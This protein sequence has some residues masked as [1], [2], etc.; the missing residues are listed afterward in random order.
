MISVGQ[1][2]KNNRPFSGAG[3]NKVQPTP[4][5]GSLDDSKNMLMEADVQQETTNQFRKQKTIL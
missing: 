1:K 5:D 3:N 4:T 2:I